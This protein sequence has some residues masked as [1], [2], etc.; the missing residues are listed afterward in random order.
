MYLPEL[1]IRG[2]QKP[3]HSM[4]S[5]SLQWPVLVINVKTLFFL[6][7]PLSFTLLCIAFTIIHS[8]H[9]PQGA[10]NQSPMGA[11]GSYCT[12]VL[13]VLFPPCFGEGSVPPQGETGPGA[14]MLE[15][16]KKAAVGGDLSQIPCCAA[17]MR[18]QTDCAAINF[19]KG[20]VH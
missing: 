17:K 13:S 18:W 10:W 12:T 1:A 8:F 5:V 3:L 16:L 6:D 20:Q 2:R 4:V 7:F 15:G 19:A 11:G 14:C 9:Y